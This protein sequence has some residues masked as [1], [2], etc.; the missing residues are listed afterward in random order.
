MKHAMGDALP[1]A[2]DP[3]W[4]VIHTKPRCEKK[5]AA[6][7]VR[8]TFEH[9]LPLVPSVRRYRNQT[10]RFSKPLFPGYV[11]VRIPI[12]LTNRLYQQDLVV[13]LVKVPDQPVFLRQL[14]A[15]RLMIR[16]GFDLRLTPL[17]HKGA[18]VRIIG[19]PLWGVQGMVED[20]DH[21]KG[22]VV[23]MDVLQQGVL[24]NIAVEHLEVLP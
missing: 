18:R 13:R 11:F 1:A 12:E 15:I 2:L 9:E 7:M 20:P 4:I 22:V 10:K 17:L 24:V 21:P 16:A 23:A 5:F 14:E 8:E 6:M 3:P 19:G